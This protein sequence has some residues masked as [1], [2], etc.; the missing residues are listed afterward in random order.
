MTGKKIC[1]SE[2]AVE[3]GIFL[4]VLDAIPG[5]LRV[6]CYNRVGAIISFP[7][8]SVLWTGSI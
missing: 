3:V 6:F 7:A 5:N 1:V 8:E 2:M 4:V